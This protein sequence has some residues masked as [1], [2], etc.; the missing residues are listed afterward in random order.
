M[1]RVDQLFQFYRGFVWRLNACNILMRTMYCIFEVVHYVSVVS[2]YGMLRW[3][4]ACNVIRK[5]K[6]ELETLLS[7]SNRIHI[8]GILVLL[9]VNML[10]LLVSYIEYVDKKT[11]SVMNLVFPSNSFN[12]SNKGTVSE[13]TIMN[14]RWD[15]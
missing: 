7:F 11:F 12:Q 13:R 14:K 9:F 5:S 8:D 15:S 6:A 1:D 3:G 2:T 10:Y 4:M